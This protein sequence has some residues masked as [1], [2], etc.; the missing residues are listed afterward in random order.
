MR[1]S[2]SSAIEGEA[3]AGQVVGDSEAALV[4]GHVLRDGGNAIDAIDAGSFL[5]KFVLQKESLAVSMAAP[6]IHTEGT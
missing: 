4:G 3:N 1:L 5:T 6:R 2:P